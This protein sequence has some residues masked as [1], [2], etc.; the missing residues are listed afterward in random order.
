MLIG[1]TPTQLNSALQTF[2]KYATS[3]YAIIIYAVIL[4][5]LVGVV[6][7][8]L[9]VGEG[10]KQQPKSLL[11]KTSSAQLGETTKA[12]ATEEQVTYDGS[13]FDGLTRI[14]EQKDIYKR[15]DYTDEITL[16]R[17]C[18]T[19]RNFSANKLKLYYDISD[20]RRFIAGMAVSHI[21]IL[22]GMSGTGKTSLA[23]A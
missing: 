2:L 8:S 12:E 10:N 11:I 23:Y 19:F 16:K 7:I 15:S 22:Q 5:V 9:M 17:L 21:L 1:I 4:L 20:I 18:E 6:V 14:D 13:R 3:G